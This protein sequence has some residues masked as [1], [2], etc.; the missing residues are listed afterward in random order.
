MNCTLPRE[1]NMKMKEQAE[2]SRRKPEVERLF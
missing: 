2:K 1:E